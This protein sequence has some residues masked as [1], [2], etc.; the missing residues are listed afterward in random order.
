MVFPIAH[1]RT[2]HGPYSSSAAFL[3]Y[4]PT[5]LSSRPASRAASQSKLSTPPDEDKSEIDDGSAG[6]EMLFF[7][8]FESSWRSAGEEDV[9]L[10]AGTSAADLNEQIW[11]QAAK[12][13]DQGRLAGVFV[14]YARPS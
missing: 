5:L 13:W 14:G 6:R 9:D 10:E 12:S 4:D 1:G 8:D 11:K 3:R 7:G 2:S